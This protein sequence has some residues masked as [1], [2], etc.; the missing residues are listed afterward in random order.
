MGWPWSE[1][2]P[3]QPI[4]LPNGSPWPRLS[5][6]TPCLNQGRFIEET[7]R[8]VLLQ[9]YPNLEYIIIDGGSTDDSIEI[10]KKYEPWLAHWISESD[11][12]QAAALAKGFSQATG[13]VFAW[14]NS[15][16]LYLANAFGYVVR[17][18]FRTAG[19]IVFGNTL[20]I[21]QWS[22]TIG[23]RRLAPYVPWLSGQG[24]FFGGYGIYQP[25]AFWSRKLYA[26]SGG[27]DVSFRF[28]M[29]NDLI[30]RFVIVGA[31]FQFVRR[32]L[33]GFR[34]HSASKTS[35]LRHVASQEYRLI[36]ERLPRCSWI[37]RAIV[38]TGCRSWRLAYHISHLEFKY[39][40]SKYIGPW[41][42][43][44]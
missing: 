39:L 1:E 8:S 20:L 14:V 24:I 2:S 44:P 12:G 29:D 33:A 43:V 34:V 25:A 22:N 13:D 28:C 11:E 7:I 36:V 30:A 40:R 32:F 6:V 41:R 18:F 16:D 9:G 23:E 10:I 31:K 35:N 26:D 19:D 15:D 5:I 42:W 4:S 27:I 38:R 17:T 3:Q 21:D 37:R